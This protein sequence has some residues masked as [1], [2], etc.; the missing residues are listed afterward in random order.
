MVVATMLPRAHNGLTIP[1]ADGPRTL[2]LFW[3]EGYASAS[4]LAAWNSYIFGI[5]VAAFVAKELPVY[6]LLQPDG[7]ASLFAGA[8][9]SP[10]Q[11][12]LLAAALRARSVEPKI[13][14]RIG[15]TF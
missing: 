1:F 9:E 15:R 2:S 5:A 13:V 4:S 8:F 7:S 14:Y 11:A 12:G 10:D 3:M 6:A